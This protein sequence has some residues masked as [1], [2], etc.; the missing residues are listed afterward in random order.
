MLTVEIDTNE[1]NQHMALIG[2]LVGIEAL[3]FRQAISTYVDKNAD[4]VLVDLEQMKSIDLTGF[5]ALVMLKKEAEDH[6]CKFCIQANNNPTFQ[7]YLHL[8]KLDLNCLKSNR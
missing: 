8:S 2:D 7:E 1:Y 3:E 5:N 4:Q 6:D